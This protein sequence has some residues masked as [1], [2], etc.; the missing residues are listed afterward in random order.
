MMTN[1]QKHKIILASKSIS[2]QKILAAAGLEAVIISSNIDENIIKND[3]TIKGAK[4]TEISEKLAQ[5]KALKIS[6]DHPDDI[7]IGGDQILVCEGRSFD[8]ANTIKEAKEN[9]QFFRGK[10][11]ELITSICI[12]KN[13]EVIWTYTTCPKLTMRDFSDDFL[14]IYVENAQEA[15]LHSV[16]CYFIEESGSQLFSKIKG[17]YYAIL[18]MPRLPLLSKLRELGVLEK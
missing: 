1:A 4:T 6:K 18:G 13:Q 10:T 9:L 14:D 16:G 15:L 8:K 12:I 7:I 11:H 2:R 17:D 3:M 5:Q